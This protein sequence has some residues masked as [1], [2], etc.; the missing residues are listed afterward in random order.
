MAA[1]LGG[2]AGLSEWVGGQVAGWLGD[3]V[4]M[5]WWAGRWVGRW[6]GEWVIAWVDYVLFCPMGFMDALTPV[7]STLPLTVQLHSLT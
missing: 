4:R 2:W 3:W 1:V 7:I 6:V 5:G